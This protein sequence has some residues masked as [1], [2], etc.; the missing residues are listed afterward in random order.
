LFLSWFPGFSWRIAGC[1]ECHRHLGWNFE[2]FAKA[3]AESD[4]IHFEDIYGIH[5]LESERV[6][7]IQSFSALIVDR[8]KWPEGVS[9]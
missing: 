5:G 1:S 3:R 2:Q 8:I 6:T 7:A 4:S 9:I